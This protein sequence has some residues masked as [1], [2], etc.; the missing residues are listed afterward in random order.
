MTAPTV[1]LPAARVELLASLL[2]PEYRDLAQSLRQKVAEAD[3]TK[4]EDRIQFTPGRGWDEEDLAIRLALMLH[5][6]NGYEPYRRQDG[7]WQL[8]SNGTW[9]LYPNDGGKTYHLQYRYG[10]SSEVWSAI[11]VLMREFGVSSRAE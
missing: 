2:P 11:R 7:T 9:M 5:S 1:P 3:A 6:E 8:D 10:K 4:D